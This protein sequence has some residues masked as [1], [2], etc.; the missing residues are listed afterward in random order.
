MRKEDE[1]SFPRRK[2]IVMALMSI[3]SVG[4][5]VADNHSGP[6]AGLRCQ[7]LLLRGAA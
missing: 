5:P 1:K 7:L 4:D 2:G 3:N 6:T